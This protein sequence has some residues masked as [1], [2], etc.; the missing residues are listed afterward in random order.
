MLAIYYTK[1][2]KIAIWNLISCVSKIQSEDQ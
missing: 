2:Y 1:E